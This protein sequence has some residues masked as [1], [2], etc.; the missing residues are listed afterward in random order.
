MR[1]GGGGDGMRFEGTG[2]D[3]KSINMGNSLV[4]GERVNRILQ[5][6][7]GELSGGV[8]RAL[9]W[10]RVNGNLPG[11]A[12]DIPNCGPSDSTLDRLSLLSSSSSSSSS[13]LVDVS[14]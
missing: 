6:D 4:V 2:G 9:P 3:S 7:G 1:K 14:L 8:S 12:K 13:S 11:G 5:V 10:V